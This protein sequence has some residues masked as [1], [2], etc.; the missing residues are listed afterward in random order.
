MQII[1]GI[2][3]IKQLKPNHRTKR[4]IYPLVGFKMEVNEYPG[5]KLS[6]DGSYKISIGVEAISKKINSGL[7]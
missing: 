4:Q 2:R 5:K 6:L 1:W 7:K 3:I